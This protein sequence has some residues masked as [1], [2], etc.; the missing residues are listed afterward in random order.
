MSVKKSLIL[1]LLIVL[2]PLALGDGLIKKP[3]ANSVQD[4]VKRLSAVLEKKGIKVFANI[5][6]QS[7]AEGVKLELGKV[8]LLLFGNPRLGTP[9]MQSNPTAGIDLPMKVLV[10]EDREGKVWLAY[11][12]PS[13][14][15][16]RHGIKDRQ[17]IVKKMS[18]ALNNMT[19]A[20]ISP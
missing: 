20:A 11:N 12:D 17:E 4:T 1:I 8:Q 13:Y 6:H 14:M 16:Q 5:D 7:N 19:N 18:M 3:S 2:S 9:L 15:V 10:W